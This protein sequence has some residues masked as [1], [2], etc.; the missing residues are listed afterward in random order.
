MASLF[1]ALTAMAVV[2][3][4]LFVLGVPGVP[5]Y[6]LSLGSGLAVLTVMDR[7]SRR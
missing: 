7:R 4:M 1:A 2:Q 3:V 5:A 6:L